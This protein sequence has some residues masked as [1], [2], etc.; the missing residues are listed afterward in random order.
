MPCVQIVEQV[1]LEGVF[2]IWL[3]ASATT[4]QHRDTAG[5]TAHM[6]DAR[7]AHEMVMRS[8]E[9]GSQISSAYGG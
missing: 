9:V 7:N 4:A 6:A 2:G 1:R 5:H 3:Q 8:R